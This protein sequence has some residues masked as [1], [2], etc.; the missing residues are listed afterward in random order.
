MCVSLL[1]HFQTE[2]APITALVVGTNILHYARS[3]FP[4]TYDNTSVY[5]GFKGVH[6]ALL[7]VGN[8]EVFSLYAKT[9]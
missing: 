6:R 9:T 4:F 1:F 2:E 8:R 3:T 7:C 5:F